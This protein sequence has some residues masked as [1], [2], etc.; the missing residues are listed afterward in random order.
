MDEDKRLN[1]VPRASSVS[2]ARTL[3]AIGEFWDEHDL[4][5]FDSDV[6]DVDFDINPNLRVL[7]AEQSEK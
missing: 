4:T 7:S 6:P 2:K 5:E 3:E 1:D